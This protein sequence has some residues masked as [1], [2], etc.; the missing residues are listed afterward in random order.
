MNELSTKNAAN[1]QTILRLKELLQKLDYRKFESL[2]AALI[3]ALLELPISVA[4]SGFQFGGDAGP[5]GRAMRTF[6]IETKRYSD[7]TSFSDRE[8]L[9][10]I[11]HA[12]VRDPGLEGW[13]LVATREVPEQLALDLAGKSAKVGVPVI[14]IDWK[15]TD[16]PELAALCTI[17]PSIVGDFCGAEAE[18]IARTNIEAMSL[19]LAGLKRELQTWSLGFEGLRSLTHSKLTEVWNTPARAIATMGQDLAGGARTSTIRRSASFAA[20]SNWWQTGSIEAAPALVCGME[21]YGKTWATFDWLDDQRDGLPI[22][23]LL[24]ASRFAGS[25]V[26][27]ETAIKALVAECLFE[28]S[29]ARGVEH[30]KGRLE[31]LLLRPFDEGPVVVLLIDGMNQEPS[32]PWLRILQCLQVPPFAGRVRVIVTTRRHHY[33][34]RLKQLSGLVVRPDEIEVTQFTDDPGGEL[35]QRLAHDGLTRGDI[36]TE[37]LPFAR[38]P[39]LYDLVIK[40]R[41]RLDTSTEVTVHRL[42]WEYGRD[43]LGIRGGN[44]FSEGEWKVWLSELADRNRTGARAFSFGELGG[45]AA[46]PDLTET[47]IYRRLSEIVDGDFVRKLP[48][49]KYKFS[50]LTV[51]HALGLALLNHLEEADMPSSAAVETALFKWLDPISGLDERSEILRASV[52]IALAQSRSI[53]GSI[54]TELLTA[55]LATQNLVEEHRAEVAGLAKPLLRPLLDVLERETHGAYHGARLIA[56]EAIR[57]LPEDDEVARTMIIERGTAWLRVFSRDVDPPSRQ[58]DQSEKARSE[59]LKKRIGR[60]E[61]GE[62][63]ILGLGLQVVERG[64]SPGIGEIPALIEGFP[65]ARARS[66]FEHNALVEALTRGSGIWDEL[67]WVVLLNAVDFRE[68]RDMLKDLSGDFLRRSPEAGVHPNLNKRVAAL[69][70]WMSGDEELEAKA[71]DLD[72]AIDA[73]PSYEADYLPDPSNSWYRLERRHID[74]VMANHELPLFRRIDRAKHFWIDPTIQVPQSFSDELIAGTT[75]FDLSNVYVG[76]GHTREDHD[77]EE[78]VVP[79]ARFAPSALADM[80]RRKLKPTTELNQGQ[81]QQLSHHSV[82]H[83]ILA[84]GEVATALGLVRQQK[85]VADADQKSY[86]NERFM[87]FEATQLGVHDQFEM[88]LNE[89][90]KY[91]SYDPRHVLSALDCEEIDSLIA[92]YGLEDSKARANLVALLSLIEP[93]MSGDAWHWLQNLALDPTFELAGVACKI[94]SRV[95]GARFGKT[96]LEHNW[97]WV[98]GAN[99]W[100]NHYGSHAVIDASTAMPFELVASVITPSLLPYAIRERGSEPSE[101]KLATEILS[102]LLMSAAAGVSDLGGEIF[103][104]SENRKN[105]PVSFSILPP[106]M[107]P[108]HPFGELKAMA[109][110]DTY[111]EHRQNAVS[112]AVERIKDARTNGARLFIHSFGAEDFAP[113]A[114]NQ[115][116]S[117][118]QWIDGYQEC[119]PEFSRRVT[120]AEGAYIALCDAIFDHAPAVAAQ[121]WRSLRKVV[122]TRFIGQGK[123]D[124]MLHMAFRHAALPEAAAILDELYTIELCHTDATLFTLA[125]AAQLNG[126][127]QWMDRKIAEDKASGEVW[128]CQRA[129]I[130]KGF[131]CGNQLP[132]EDSGSDVVAQ[133][134]RTSRHQKM[135]RWQHREAC[136]MHWWQAYW[137]APTAEDAYAAWV[138]FSH[139]ADRRAHCWMIDRLDQAN[140]HEPLVRMK[141]AHFRLNYDNLSRAMEKKEK[142]FDTEFLGRRIKKGIRPWRDT[143]H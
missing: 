87:L 111:A 57:S 48:S 101:V 58:N 86:I 103:V 123:I 91:I 54:I 85:S 1:E 112:T 113:F 71:A 88:F 76:M 131:I 35:D 135:L 36:H 100:T 92:K 13:F 62:F 139:A 31:R 9:G 73:W 105:D 42:L 20:L 40:L 134:L 64:G 89:N 41:D 115:R 120:M 5:A 133:D 38:T 67:K 7:T 127:R 25:T 95:D 56:L 93:Q 26:A 124:E 59:H 23:L 2:A 66:I 79:L 78:F 77:L 106:P 108:D 102:S 44:A 14:A 17:A 21:G 53:S 34:D 104:N 84:T 30:W 140:E 3:G 43:T 121:L 47:E 132:F 10:E 68:T 27:S 16:C 99:D 75:L 39:R 52:N 116:A 117:V 97:N 122:R 90:P 82:E 72:P 8:L 98:P 4:K 114:F 50:D 45:M 37:L 6:R 51:V 137:D 55:W 118:M 46:Q 22:V 128:R 69:L 80:I 141:L 109:Q 110:P 60:D 24:P 125:L 107:Y 129:Q 81:R 119:T 142:D 15:A 19:T 49:G 65:L 94:L 32:V 74:Q 143:R 96:L 11:D 29:K 130:L 33:E 83:F 126:Q 12:I 138:L 136:A 70:L 18:N 61:D 63:T 28:V